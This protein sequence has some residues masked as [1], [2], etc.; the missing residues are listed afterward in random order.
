MNVG[1]QQTMENV[2]HHNAQEAMVS[3]TV[4]HHRDWLYDRYYDEI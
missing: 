1:L 4:A 3:E 2:R